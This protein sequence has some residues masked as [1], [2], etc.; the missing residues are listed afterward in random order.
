MGNA[1]EH[2]LAS[3]LAY[4]GDI[5][6]CTMVTIGS[7]VQIGL[8]LFPVMILVAWAMYG[9]ATATPL[10]YGVGDVE[11]VITIMSVIM[12]AFVIASGQANYMQGIVMMCL[13]F[14]FATAYFVSDESITLVR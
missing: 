1:A 9:E 2:A 13:Y 4:K 6:G 10:T 14:T 12:V 5:H 7:A 11:F 8:F 3:V